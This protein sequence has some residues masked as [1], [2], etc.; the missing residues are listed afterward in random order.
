MIAAKLAACI[1]ENFADIYIM[2][3]ALRSIEKR[4]DLDEPEVIAA[5]ATVADVAVAQARLVSRPPTVLAAG[6]RAALARAGLRPPAEL[7]W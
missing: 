5:I 4:H 3:A 2:E 1:I 7:F 6:L